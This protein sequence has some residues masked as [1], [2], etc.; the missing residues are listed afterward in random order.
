MLEYIIVKFIN[1]EKK[2]KIEWV[3]EN[4]KFFKF[5]VLLFVYKSLFVK[6]V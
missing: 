5:D 4:I 2:R 3:N 1:R 6:V